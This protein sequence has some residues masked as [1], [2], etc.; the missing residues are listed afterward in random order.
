MGEK[1]GGGNRQVPD[2]YPHSRLS[3]GLERR[4]RLSDDVTFVTGHL[5]LRR[6]AAA[7]T[8]GCSSRLY[9]LPASSV[10]HSRSMCV[11]AR[12]CVC[13]SERAALA[14]IIRR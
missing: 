4:V 11:R 13:V 7:V 9:Y 3:V 5:V 8:P 2:G 12:V 10:I 6:L 1:M 14:L